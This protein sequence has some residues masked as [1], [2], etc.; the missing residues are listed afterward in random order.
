MLLTRA[1][2]YRGRSPFSFDLHVLSAPL[3]FVLSQ[4]QTLQLN[5]G[6]AARRPRLCDLAVTS[7]R[8]VDSD[9]CLE[10][11]FGSTSDRGDP[12]GLALSVEPTSVEVS[13]RFSFQGPRQLSRFQDPLLAGRGFLLPPRCAVK[14][15]FLLSGPKVAFASFVGTRRS[16]SVSL[17]R[18]ATFWST[19]GASFRRPWRSGPS[20]HSG[21]F[22]SGQVKYFVHTFHTRPRNHSVNSRGP[23]LGCGAPSRRGGATYSR[24]TR[25]QTEST[26]LPHALFSRPNSRLFTKA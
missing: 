4:D 22:A 20:L 21:R 1:P 15:F 13:V 6:R 16:I 9:L 5:S 18:Q 10:S 7:S 14:K 3:T 12:S 11:H 25:S 24:R 26:L 8:V 17:S 23:R 2:L 19:A